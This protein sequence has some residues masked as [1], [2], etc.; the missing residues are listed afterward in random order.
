GGADWTLQFYQLRASADPVLLSVVHLTGETTSVALDAD[1]RLAYVGLGA[2]GVALVDL[3]G[4]ASIQP[5]DLDH[6]GVDDRVLGLVDTPGHAERVTLALDR[7]IGLV[8]DGE[9]G[10]TT[11]QLIPPRVRFLSLTRDPSLLLS[12]EE[13]SI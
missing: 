13:Q 7:G 4:P 11:V 5:I 6:N 8:A 1:E 3:D 10:V 9:A 12:G 2:R